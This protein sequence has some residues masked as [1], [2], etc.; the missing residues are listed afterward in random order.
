MNKKTSQ[1]IKLGIFVAFGLVIFIAAV[2]YLGS[3]QNLFS[4]S[5]KLYAK[6]GNVNGLKIGNNIRYAGI[7]VGTVNEIEIINDTT[8]LVTMMIDKDASTFIKEN[9][10]AEVSSEGLMGNKIVTVSNGSTSAGAINEGDTLPS[11][12]PIQIDEIMRTVS[13]T[14][15]NVLSISNDIAGMIDAITSGQGMLGKLIA[16]SSTVESF[17]EITRTFDRSVNNLSTMSDDLTFLTSQ[18]KQGEGALGKLITD[19]SFAHEIGRMSDTLKVATT[20]ISSI[21]RDLAKFSDKLS[22]SDGAINMLLEDTATAQNLQNTILNINQMA[23]EVEITAQKVN[24][25]WLLNG[26]LGGRDKNNN[27]EEKKM[28]AQVKGQ[29]KRN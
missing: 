27:K 14:G 11:V 16:D 28:A 8:I 29:P 4:D 20:Y 22:D 2:Y 7:N 6:F 24:N 26:L 19:E 10:Q 5:T 9:S 18:I 23:Q 1:N 3:Q 12:D 21:T 13:K 15:Q 25:S 17:T